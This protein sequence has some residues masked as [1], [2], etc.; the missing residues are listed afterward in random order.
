MDL[1]ALEYLSERKKPI[2]FCK[3]TTLWNQGD[4]SNHFLYQINGQTQL[5]A[6]EHDGHQR[7]VLNL[8]PGDTVG[9]ISFFRSCP[10]I[11]KAIVLFDSDYYKIDRDDVEYFREHCPFFIE[12][13]M[14]E[15]ASK[16]DVLINH[17]TETSFLSAEVKVARWIC[18]WEWYGTSELIDGK[19][20]L[21]Y[22]QDTI[23][24]IV[25][26]SRWSVNKVLATFKERGWVSTEYG[27]LII[28]DLE[29]IRSFG[30]PHGNVKTNDADMNDD[31]HTWEHYGPLD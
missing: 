7:N 29:A 15:F 21:R 18:R 12:S 4:P 22:R 8:W 10:R 30:Y 25:G 2:S 13:I 6:L 26:L 14:L 27:G 17:V 23:G 11:S 9:A 3:G 16:I 19:H 31:Q 28:N 20:F 5:F 24:N 1:N